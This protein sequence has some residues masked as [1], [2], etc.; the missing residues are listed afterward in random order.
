MKS[1]LPYMGGKSRL[2]RAIV[3]SMPEHEAYGE[4]FAGAG[5]VFFAKPRSRHE[6][7]NDINGELVSFYRVLQCHLEEFLRQFKWALSSRE[8]FEDWDRQLRSGGLTDIQKAARFYY[9]Q[10]HSFCGKV[11]G[12]AFG[13][14]PLHAPKINLVRLEEDL[15]AVHLRLA[16][17]TI[18]RLPWETY[19]ERYDRRMAEA[20]KG[21]RGKF[22]MSI[23]DVPEIRAIFCGFPTTAVKTSYSSR[24]ENRAA[25]E[26]LIKN[27]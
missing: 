23:N 17:A 19:I 10:R 26:L 6:S 16:G 11:A 14:S 7:I 2:A 12:R 1:P 27:F 8:M 4:V 13:A 9:L 5:W 20:L 3:E 24:R 21:I 18:E 22:I 25:S 15:S